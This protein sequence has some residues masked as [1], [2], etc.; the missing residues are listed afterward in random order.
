I[1]KSLANYRVYLVDDG[2]KDN[3]AKVAEQFAQELPI[4]VISHDTNRGL[5]AAIETGI[6][7]LAKILE[8]GSVVVTMDSDLTHSPELVPRMLREIDRGSDIVI[9]SR[10]VRGG[11]QLRLPLMRRLLSRGVNTI[12]WIRGSKVLDNTSG[13]RCMRIESLTKAV[14]VYGSD[15]ITESG[16]TGA[17][18]KEIPLI[19]DY[20]NKKGASKMNIS[21]TIR[22]YVK[23]FIKLR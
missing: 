2:S 22:A 21:H 4:E 17:S 12:L 16:F 1:D 7:H 10:Y 15:L 19:L 3:T 20:G 13:F 9:A 5:G 18:V 11:K 6:F 14:Q 8:P 23:L